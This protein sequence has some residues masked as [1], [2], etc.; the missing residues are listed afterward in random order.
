[1]S[2]AALPSTRPQN[3]ATTAKRRNKG[4]GM[5]RQRSD[6]RWEYRFDVRVE[7]H[8]RVQKSV[9]G[10]TKKECLTKAAAARDDQRKGVLVTGPRQTFGA[11]VDQWLDNHIAPNRA[12]KTASSYRQMA[13][14]HIKPTLG[15]LT[16]ASITAAHL[17]DLYR[18]KRET[19]APRTVA[20]LHAI[21]RSALARAERQG[22]IGFN[23]CRR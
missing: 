11:Y 17:E 13:R 22:I 14:L 6:G 12:K 9:Y 1:M 15:H 7:G 21:I 3:T 5:F 16:L 18:V 2:I 23:P 19:L 10:K 20:Y 8:K 4:E